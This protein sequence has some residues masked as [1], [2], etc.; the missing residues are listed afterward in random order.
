[1][2]QTS[3]LRING[4]ITIVKAFRIL[5]IIRLVK[6]AK[7]L[8]LIFNTFIASLPALFNV[9]GLLLLILYIYSILGMELFGKIKRSDPFSDSLNFENFQNAFSALWA[10]VTGDGWSKIMFSSIRQFS[11]LF[12][13]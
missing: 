7:N 11:I 6:R 5:R 4:A 9:G 8:N 12:Q 2:A 1:M 3:V 10:V 13:C